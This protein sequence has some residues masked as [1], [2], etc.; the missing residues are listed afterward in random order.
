MASNTR[1]NATKKMGVLPR[2]WVKFVGIFLTKW[3]KGEQ[4]KV[5]NF[6]KNFEKKNIQK[7]QPRKS[8]KPAIKIRFWRSFPA[9]RGFPP[10]PPTAKF[11]SGTST[12]WP[13]NYRIWNSKQIAENSI[14]YGVSWNTINCFFFIFCALRP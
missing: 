5:A 2:K 1:T 3:T 6:S 10:A 9:I 7:F 14:Q 13:L 8:W 12:R 11:F 4:L